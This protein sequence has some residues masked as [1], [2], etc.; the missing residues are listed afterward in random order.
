MI[1]NDDTE[2]INRSTRET[3]MPLDG[4][5]LRN[6]FQLGHIVIGPFPPGP[7]TACHI[8]AF[9]PGHTLGTTTTPL[10]HSVVVAF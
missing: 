8:P 10:A 9:P 6:Q 7:L 5:L 1:A 3:P 4:E 2:F